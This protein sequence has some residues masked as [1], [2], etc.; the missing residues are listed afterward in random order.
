MSIVCGTDFSEAS[1]RA[2]TAAAALA[3]RWGEP[4]HL[5]HSLELGKEVTFD[6]PR[7]SLTSWAEDVLSEK[8]ERVKKLGVEMHTHVRPGMADE[9]LLDLG[10]EVGARLLVVSA[11]GRNAGRAALGRHADRISR[12]AHVP[13]L[14]ARDVSA[15]EAWVT[16]E[17]PLK[18]VV[19]ADLSQTSDAALRWLDG[20]A[21]AGPCEVVLVHLYW[22]PAEFQRLGLSGVRSFLDPDP[23]V[24]RTLERD[25]GERLAKFPALG[26]VSLRLEPNLGRLD[27]RLATL[28]HEEKADLLVVGSHGRNIAERIWEGSVSRGAVRFAKCSVLC[29]PT[30]A[31]IEPTHIPRFEHLLVATDFS[32]VGNAAVPIALAMAPKGASLHV[33]HVVDGAGDSLAPR[34]IF[35]RHPAKPEEYTEAQRRLKELAATLPSNDARVDLHVLCSRH[36]ADAIAQAAERLGADII[37]I[38]THGRVGVTRALLGSVA[39]GVLKATHRPV[40]FAR[41]PVE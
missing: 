36:P 33:V 16:Q 28:A 40:V 3:K 30:P 34:D 4:L 9:A 13:V 29:V 22:P 18:V 12:L 15:L 39:Q 26:R 20:L 1:L 32:V 38:G 14:V 23:D 5:L 35:E 27:Q 2:I 10:A 7:A 37:C 25:F 21:S 31:L 6:E 41:S 24:T 19:G 8:T 11:E 17:R